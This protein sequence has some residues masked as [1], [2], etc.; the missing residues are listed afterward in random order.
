M[1]LLFSRL[2]FY[3]DYFYDLPDSICWNCLGTQLQ[4]LP[5]S[6]IL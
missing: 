6:E 3:C 1:N 4:P 5:F 2:C